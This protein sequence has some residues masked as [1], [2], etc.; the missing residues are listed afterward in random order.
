MIPLVLGHAE[1]LLHEKETNLHICL[2]KFRRMYF[3]VCLRMA[4]K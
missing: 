3:F 2:V 4:V 1:I